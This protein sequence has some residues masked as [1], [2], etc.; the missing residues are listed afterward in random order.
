MDGVGDPLGVGLPGVGEGVGL[1]EAE[2]TALAVVVREGDPLLVGVPLGWEE[3]VGRGGLGLGQGAVA[4][5]EGEREG[6]GEAVP[7]PPS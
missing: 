4:E 2:G 6:K 7:L 3:G 5:A 1:R